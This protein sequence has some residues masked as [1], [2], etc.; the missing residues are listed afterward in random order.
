MTVNS[1]AMHYDPVTRRVYP[2]TFLINYAAFGYYAEEIFEFHPGISINIEAL[3]L[4]NPR[5]QV[6]LLRTESGQNLT[7]FSN[8]RFDADGPYGIMTIT[9]GPC[10]YTATGLP[11]ASVADAIT[12]R[13]RP[14]NI[15]ALPANTLVQGTLSADTPRLFSSWDPLWGMQL[16]VKGDPGLCYGT[17]RRF[18]RFVTCERGRE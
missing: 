14:F 3:T 2:E 12:V 5:G 11:C 15:T 1:V 7:L 18:V 9:P 16:L 6:V 4:F 13:L 17:A 8:Y 10:T